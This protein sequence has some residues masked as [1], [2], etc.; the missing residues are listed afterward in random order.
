MGPRRA[1]DIDKRVVKILHGLLNLRLL[2]LISA[3]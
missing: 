3:L 1:Q 2:L